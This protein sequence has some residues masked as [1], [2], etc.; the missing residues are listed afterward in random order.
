[1]I[2]PRYSGFKWVTRTGTEFIPSLSISRSR[3]C[4]VRWRLTSASSC[5][6]LGK[7]ASRTIAE[8]F[9]CLREMDQ[10]SVSD[11]DVGD[12]LLRAQAK[13]GGCTAGIDKKRVI[14]EERRQV[15]A[16]NLPSRTT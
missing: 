1:M 15:M 14:N 4:G 12:L 6:R 11:E 9:L 3:V 2:S 10:M 7:E 5:S 13:C 8:T 16:W